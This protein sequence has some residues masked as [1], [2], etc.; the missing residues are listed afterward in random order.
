MKG[1]QHRIVATSAATDAVAVA[2]NPT[3]VRWMP[4]ARS[5]ATATRDVAVAVARNLTEVRRWLMGTPRCIVAARGPAELSLLC[6][7]VCMY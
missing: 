2:R 1:T 6:G 3:E 4:T 5:A 7:Y